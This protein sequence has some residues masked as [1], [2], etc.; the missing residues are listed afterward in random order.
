MVLSRIDTAP[1]YEENGRSWSRSR[2]FWPVGAG[3]EIVDKLEPEPHNRSATLI[4]WHC[5][6]KTKV[7]ILIVSWDFSDLERSQKVVDGSPIEH[8]VKNVN[9]DPTIYEKLYK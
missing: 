4:L 9:R 6:F 5:H 7:K 8:K 2:N 1:L 3:A